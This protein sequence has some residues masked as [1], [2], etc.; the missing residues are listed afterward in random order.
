MNHDKNHEILI[1]KC[2]T[3]NFKETTPNT[4]DKGNMKVVRFSDENIT[5]TPSYAEV[6][7]RALSSTGNNDNV[8]ATDQSHFTHSNGS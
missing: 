1:P 4:R 5:R 2:E 7:R 3:D 8:L 6:T